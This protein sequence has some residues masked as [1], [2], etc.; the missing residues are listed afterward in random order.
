MKWEKNTA[1]D[2]VMGTAAKVA[3]DMVHGTAAAIQD[4]SRYH[5]MYKS[6][7]GALEQAAV[8]LQKHMLRK[9][10]MS[11]E[12]KKKLRRQISQIRAMAKICTRMALWCTT[13]GAGTISE[14]KKFE[15]NRKLADVVKGIEADDE[16]PLDA[17]D[18]PEEK[19]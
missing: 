14:L 13:F 12:D 18:E 16:D 3:E 1:A 7:G 11:G 9:K 5:G 4:I 19:D 17:N 6:M 10:W 2:I 8:N 15:M